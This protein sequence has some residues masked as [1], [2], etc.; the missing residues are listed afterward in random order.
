MD[1]LLIILVSV[2]ILISLVILYF[3]FKAKPKQEEN[4]N[5]KI[6]DEDLKSLNGMT[7]PMLA[8]LAKENIIPETN[9]NIKVFFIFYL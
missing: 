1:S 2:L 5:E 7:I 8:L 6:Q 4:P 3:Q 9:A